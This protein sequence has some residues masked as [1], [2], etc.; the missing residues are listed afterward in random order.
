MK[1]AAEGDALCAG[2]ICQC[3]SYVDGL[4]KEVVQAEFRR[5]I[6]FFVEAGVDFVIAEVSL[7]VGI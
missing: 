3:P 5:Q 7:L 4:G 2:G 6:Q 1:V